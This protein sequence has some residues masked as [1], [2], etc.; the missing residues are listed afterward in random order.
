[1]NKLLYEQVLQELKTKICIFARTKK[2]STAPKSKNYYVCSR[3]QNFF[4]GSETKYIFK[5]IVYNPILIY[6]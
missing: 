4:F 6:F 1:M 3:N 5:P 2:K